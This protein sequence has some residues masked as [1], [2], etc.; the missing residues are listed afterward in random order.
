MAKKRSGCLIGIVLALAVLVVF[1]AILAATI[2]HGAGDA[3]PN[4][5]P[6][7]TPTGSSVISEFPVRVD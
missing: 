6:H 2:F 4:G 3:N 7:V 1:V 5:L